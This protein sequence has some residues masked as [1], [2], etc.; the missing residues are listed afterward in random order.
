[1]KQS[2]LY[3]FIKE[4]D[5]NV[6]SSCNKCI[7]AISILCQIFLKACGKWVCKTIKHPVSSSLNKSKISIILYM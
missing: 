6:N 2:S 1:M 7:S 3:I 5:R 4:S